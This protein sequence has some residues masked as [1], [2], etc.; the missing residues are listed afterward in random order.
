MLQIKTRQIYSFKHSSQKR[1][2]R[3]K[4]TNEA[5]PGALLRG[6]ALGT[7]FPRREAHKALRLDK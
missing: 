5:Q 6:K 7:L 3:R 1:V 4:G 2:P